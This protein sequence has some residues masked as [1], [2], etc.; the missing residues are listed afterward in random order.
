MADIVHVG[1]GLPHCPHLSVT[2]D[3][4]NSQGE[5]QRALEQ[6]PPEIHRKMLPSSRTIVLRV[7][8]KT[9]RTAVEKADAVVQAKNG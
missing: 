5:L 6:L 7:T 4:Q 9:I 8:S 2:M 1:E 3:A